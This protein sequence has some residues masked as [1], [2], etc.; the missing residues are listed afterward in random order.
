MIKAKGENDLP[1]LEVLDDCD[2]A[3]FFTRRLTID[4]EQ[5]ARVKKYVESGRPIVGVRTA[6]HGF[7]NWLEFDR[8]VQGGNYHG[9]YNNDITA[10]VRVDKK[11]ANH[12]VLR[13]IE[14]IASRG[15]LYKTGPLASDANLLMTASS[16]EGSE[17][18][19]W[20][21]EYKGARIFYTSLGAVG[22]FENSTFRRLLA[23]ALFWT[24]ARCSG[25]ENQRRATAVEAETKRFVEVKHAYARGDVQ[26]L[27]RF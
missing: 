20:T 14:E 13:G 27:R 2:V 15:S 9:H 5:L 6:S 3:L 21:R 24:A 10:I 4:G 16:P 18:G 22:D 12:P 1:G 26:R 8:L 23:N 7:Q 25:R 19:T 17:P 11:A